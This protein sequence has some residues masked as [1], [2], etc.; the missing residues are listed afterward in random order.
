MPNLA[1]AARLFAAIH[2]AT[3]DPAGGVTRDAYGP[4]ERAAHALVRAEATA[5]GLETS[6]DPA[7]NLYMTRPGRDRDAPRI[8][9]GSHLDSVPQGGDYDGTAGVV[10]GLAVL[11][12]LPHVPACDVSVMAIRAEEAGAWFPFGCPGSRAALGTLPAHALDVPRL[13]TGR[14][15]A[16]HME[17]EGFDPDAIRR[18]V[19]TLHPGKVAAFVEL[20][21]EQGPVLDALRIPVGIVTGIPGSRRHRFGRVLGR[22]DHS[23]G[24]PRA[25][26]SDAALAVADL[27]VQL[28]AAWAAL[29]A[30]GHAL[31]CTMCVLA[32]GAQAGFGKV[33]GEAG[34]KLDVRS[35]DQASLDA[36]FATLHRMVPE[37]EATRRVRI[38]L[39]PESAG[40][41]TPLDP[42]LTAALARAAEAVG[43][44]YRAMPS[45]GGHDASAFAQAGIPAAMLFVRN[46][47]G[48]HSP[49]EAMRPEDFATACHV[50][51]RWLVDLTT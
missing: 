38:E 51:E 44:P 34:F 33:A 29:E 20:H 41:P 50:L 16:T 1:L 8:I 13:D 26:R 32:T 21:I 27:A 31:V 40:S 28:D 17:E 49:N 43:V 7:G 42:A 10:A 36:L 19:A 48:S 2:D 37:I 18:G 47:N 30:E 3:R 39:G 14:S 35:Q 5:L 4:G 15:L 46:Q 24:T 9:L 45:G 6:T 23:G 11:A 12:G 25:Y 22:W